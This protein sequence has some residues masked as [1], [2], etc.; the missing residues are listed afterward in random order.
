MKRAESSTME[1]SALILF[2]IGDRAPPCPDS[3]GGRGASGHPPPSTSAGR[4]NCP[5]LPADTEPASARNRPQPV[6]FPGT[7]IGF[8]TEAASLRYTPPAQT[9]TSARFRHAGSR[10]TPLRHQ[11]G[12]SPGPSSDA[13]IP[14]RLPGWPPLQ[15][16][17]R[18]ITQKKPGAVNALRADCSQSDCLNATH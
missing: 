13:E 9:L 7:R 6:H 11:P 8:G 4:L 18:P 5:A 15:V 12:S 10:P 16:Q 1:G 17:A 3:S 14:A 2:Y